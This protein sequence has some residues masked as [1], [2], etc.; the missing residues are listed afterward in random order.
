[1]VNNDIRQLLN[2]EVEDAVP[3]FD[4]PA[5]D[6]AIIGLDIQTGAV[7]YDYDAMV[8]EYME[9]NNCDMFDA[10]EFIDYNTIRAIP[11]FP[12]PQ[13]IIVRSL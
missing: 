12:E 8:R 4:C 11:Y 7:V 6:G 3:V 1:M 10:M 13:P 9:D 5:F 2:D